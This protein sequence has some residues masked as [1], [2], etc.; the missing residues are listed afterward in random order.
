MSLK[1]LL[2]GAAVAMTLASAPA[3]AETVAEILVRN[4]DLSTFVSAIEA[5]GLTEQIETAQTIT[6][7]A[8]SNEAFEALPPGVF[9]AL[10]ADKAKLKDVVLYHFVEG[11]V[12]SEKPKGSALSIAALNG[13][14]L[15]DVIGDAAV[16]EADKRASNGVVHVID[17]VLLTRE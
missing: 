8:P 5:A 1:S 14:P 2:A 4:P 3:M 12:P 7:F 10:Q 17:T 13:K 11:E 6:V 15:K 9:D 16:V